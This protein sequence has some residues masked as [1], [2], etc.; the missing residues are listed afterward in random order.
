MSGRRACVASFAEGL[1]RGFERLA[2]AAGLAVCAVAA[3]LWWM[4]AG[5]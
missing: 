1:A 5:T 2:I 3:V 4:E